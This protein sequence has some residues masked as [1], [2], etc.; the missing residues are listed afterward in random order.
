[1]TDR[2]TLNS[3]IRWE[4]ESPRRD[5]YDVLTN[6]DFNARSP[7]Q[8]PGYDL[9]GGLTFVGVNGISRYNTNPD[10]NNVSP[11]LGIAYRLF[12]KTIVRSGA[13]IFFASSTGIGA[14]S[15][16]FGISGF[17]TSTG[18]VTSLDGVTP[19]VSWRNPY[20]QGLNRPTGS[21]QGLA[22]LL[23]QD[24]AFFNRGNRLPY[25]SHWNFNIQQELPFASV[26]EIG[27][28]GS[29][30]IKFPQNRSY[31]QIPDSALAFG[32]GLRQQVANPFRGQIA[33]GTL[34]NPTVARVQL[35]RPFPHFGNVVSMNEDWAS[36]TWH[37]LES[38]LEKRFSRGFLR[39]LPHHRQAR[40][41]G[42][43]RG[44][45]GN[46]HQA[47]SGSRDQGNSVDIGW[48]IPAAWSAS[49]ARRRS[50]LR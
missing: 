5:R 15:A 6:F 32:D 16:A 17:Q 45:A 21:T 44:L 43:G 46:R 42:H 13:G 40:R 10:R 50:W 9:R 2:L 23:G 35:L 31:N 1:V 41:R 24:I 22:T 12:P 14:N 26:F 30:G 38:S 37:A 48:T 11:R 25:S 7:L 8:V 36:S 49:S 18:L 4:Y 47:Q 34:A 39:A 29:R 19:I 27:Y 33:V 3:G 28:A 20:P